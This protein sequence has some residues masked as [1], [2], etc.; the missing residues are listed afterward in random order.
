M[1]ATKNP[2]RWLFAIL[3][4][5][6]IA[7]LSGCTASGPSA[8][9]DGDRALRDGK[10]TRA[11]EDLKRAT[12]LIPE[13]PR[14]WNCLGVAYHRSNQPQLAAQAYGQ[15]LK[16]DRSNLVAIAHFNLGCLLLE[17]G[18]AAG[19]VDEL[20][21][22]TMTTNSAL[23]WLKLGEAQLRLRQFDAAERSL[24]SALRLQDKDLQP[25][26]WNDLGVLY[27]Q[28]NRARE[29]M[30]YFN[31]ALQVNP[32]LTPAM[33]NIAVLAQQSMG[34]KSYALQRY[35]EYLA[36]QPKAANLE[37][38]SAM[39]RQLES[40]LA[41]RSIPQTNAVAQTVATNPPVVAVP[42]NR[43]PVIATS[44]VPKLVSVPPT[45]VPSARVVPLPQTNVVAAPRTP[46]AQTNIPPNVPITVVAVA[47]PPPVFVATSSPAITRTK[48]SPNVANNVVPPLVTAPPIAGDPTL[49]RPNKPGLLQRM[50]PFR[51]KPERVA[52]METGRVV[53]AS[54]P[55]STAAPSIV[56]PTPKTFA[57][58]RYANPAPPK[59]GNRSEAERAF[60]QGAKA[61]R[62]SNT[63]EALLDYQRAISADPS[64]L[65]AQYNL[66][67]LAQQAG[68]VRRSLGLW[69]TV[70]AIEPD[71]INARYNF[72]L[73]LKQADFPNEAAV[74]LEKILEA[75]PSESR[76]HL[77]LAN[78]SAQQLN[79][80]RRARQH[81][82]KVLQL[83]PRN[84]Q[85]S[86][87]RFWLA[88]NP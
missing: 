52:T 54:I 82:M 24:G 13:E 22:F 68:D 14:A 3:L 39:V 6:G 79:D 47:P 20:R 64:F 58:Y 18:N 63:N 42:T 2:S 19:A 35:R 30:Q 40:D 27:A 51:S 60:Q 34:S 85:A 80:N 87:I 57:R 84:S 26:V 83:E 29:A 48:P 50:N 8:L 5:A 62:A 9:L 36:L 70:L 11:V 41:P 32:K 21:S 59:S 37:A 28:R 25:M 1:L 49:D 46:P 71:S 16:R 67:L 53:V 17:Q 72:A 77:T 86:A 23:G 78:L 31:N 75:K 69:E 7:I 66:A 38:V 55:P 45:N 61:Q 56:A 74:E 15:A 88:A 65:D 43:S 12:E 73:A 4:A 10:L 33:L 76:A 44:A 81:Y